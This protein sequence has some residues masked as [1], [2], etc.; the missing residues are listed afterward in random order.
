MRVKQSEYKAFIEKMIQKGMD[1]EG[2]VFFKKRGLLHIQSQ[3][4]AHTFSFF[5]KKETI[6]NAQRQ[7]EKKETYFLSLPS[8]TTESISWEKVMSTFETWLDSL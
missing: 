4:K 2:F 5:R 1:P 3:D 8:K 6:L 7:W